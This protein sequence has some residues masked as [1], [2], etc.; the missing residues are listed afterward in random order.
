MHSTFSFVYLLASLA[1]AAVLS[2]PRNPQN[3]YEIEVIQPDASGSLKAFAIFTGTATNFLSPH[4]SLPTEAV[5]FENKYKPKQQ[6]TRT[7]SADASGFTGFNPV[8]DE[9]IPSDN[10]F[11]SLTVTGGLFGPATG[12]PTTED[13][14]LDENIDGTGTATAALSGITGLS[15]Y[16]ENVKVN[17]ELPAT[18]TVT[19]AL[20]GGTGGLYTEDESVPVEG[21]EGFPSLTSVASG[22]TGAATGVS[23]FSTMTSSTML[24]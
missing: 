18:G 4:D 11:P 16:K 2:A 3:R 5:K 21:G 7:G 15:R 24:Q 22:Y 10:S 9:Y 19:A 13:E 12:L 20:A 17:S 14:V 1:P 6:G 8:E 23:T